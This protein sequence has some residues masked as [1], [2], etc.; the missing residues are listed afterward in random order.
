METYP[1]GY[2][3]RIKSGVAKAVAIFCVPGGNS[4]INLLQTLE[5]KPTRVDDWGYGW[6]RREP[7]GC[8][9]PGYMDVFI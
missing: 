4:D 7:H 1:L 8:G 5:A 3:H 6:Q 2:G 9:N